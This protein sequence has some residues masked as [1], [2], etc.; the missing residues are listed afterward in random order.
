MTRIRQFDIP[1]EDL[2]GYSRGDKIFFGFMIILITGFVGMMVAI[3]IDLEVVTPEEQAEIDAKILYYETNYYYEP[4]Y[5][6]ENVYSF[7]DSHYAHDIAIFLERNPT[8]EVASALD[9]NWNEIVV[10]FREKT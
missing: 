1:E 9:P 8:L 5:N 10:I 6:G 3:M 7:N 4:E 2:L